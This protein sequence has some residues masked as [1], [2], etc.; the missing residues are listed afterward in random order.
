[1]AEL[2]GKALAQELIGASR[3]E[4]SATPFSAV[5]AAA[6][7]GTLDEPAVV[8]LMGRLWTLERMFY[9][10][11][12][13]WGQGLEIN[14]FP[15]SVKY[16]F[17]KQIVDE[18]THEMMY[19]D[20]LLRRGAVATQKQAF[21]APYGRFA[22]D[23]A[24]AYYVF[25][26]RNLATYP[27]PIRIA[28][29][30]LGPKVVEFGWMEELSVATSDTELR[31]VFASQAVEN[32][33]HINMGRRIVEEFIGRPVDA[34]LCRWACAVARRDYGRFLHE[35]SDF[36]LDRSTAPPPMPRVQVTD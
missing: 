28:A 32:R 16:L 5:V 25:S 1:M 9:Y 33:S 11:Y 26:L 2:P 10:I 15:P 22:V 14:D 6:R 36:V 23:S 8:R 4:A 31:A 13:G 3:E 12:G 34:E 7:H 29:L 19:L 17:S 20:A 24:L 21:E 27:H 30:N 35:L 18:S